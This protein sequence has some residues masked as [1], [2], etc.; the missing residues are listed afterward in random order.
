M[1]RRHR[2][3]LFRNAPGIEIMKWLG[4]CSLFCG[5]ASIINSA[6]SSPTRCSSTTLVSPQQ[7]SLPSAPA[8][9]FPDIPSSTP[10]DHNPL[11]STF[12]VTPRGG[13]P[14]PIVQ[15]QFYHAERAW[16]SPRSA[17]PTLSPNHPRQSKKQNPTT[18]L[19]PKIR[20]K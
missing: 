4:S 11:N 10:P 17:P 6:V 9:G 13:S 7:S 3:D 20:Q 1:S 15:P 18:S 16:R 12:S 5:E 14:R 2:L 19:S 8:S